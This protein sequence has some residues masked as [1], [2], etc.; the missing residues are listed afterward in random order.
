MPWPGNGL[1]G[2]LHV[3]V[4]SV[5]R[6]EIEVDKVRVDSDGL[7]LLLCASLSAAGGRLVW[8]RVDIQRTGQEEDSMSRLLQVC[9]AGVMVLGVLVAGCAMKPKLT[10]QQA[11]TLI[12]AQY[13]QQPPVS[14]VIFVNDDG[15]KAG[16]VAKYWDRSKAYSNKYWADFKLTDAGKKVIKLPDGGDTIAWHPESATDTKYVITLSPVVANHLKAASASDPQNGVNAQTETVIYDEVASLQGAP[17]PVQEM[18]R[19]SHTK[20]ST[21][22]T[23]T[24]VLEN[25]EWKL[26]SIQ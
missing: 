15:M 9:A 17:P 5:D 21:Q 23:A 7:M 18:A 25:G 14:A 16:V 12:Q 13:D 3:T 11:L 6:R 22:R 20:V 4:N 1:G 10:S 8:N 26:Q 24:F 2:V 19:D